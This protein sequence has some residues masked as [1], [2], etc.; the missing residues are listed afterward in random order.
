MEPRGCPNIFGTN[1]QTMQHNIPEQRRNKPE[2][3]SLEER[4]NI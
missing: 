2:V 4:F 3:V 1:Y